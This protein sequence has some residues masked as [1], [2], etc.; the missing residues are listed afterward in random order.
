MTFDDIDKIYFLHL[1]DRYDREK[2]LQSQLDK[3]NFPKDKVN[4]WWTCRRNISNEIW[5]YIPLL[6]RENYISNNKYAN[7]KMG[8]GVF[9][10][11]L[12]HYTIIRTSYERDFNHILVCE[13]D[14]KFNVD[15]K[16]FKK[17]I[18]LIPTNYGIC[19]F[20]NRGY[21]ITET[22]RTLIDDIST[23]SKPIPT[24]SDNIKNPY[25]IINGP[26]QST[27]CYLLDRNGM[28]AIINAYNQQFTIAD[29]I[30]DYVNIPIYICNYNIIQNH[31]Y[32]CPRNEYM[33]SD[34]WQINTDWIFNKFK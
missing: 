16:L 30:F 21:I 12:E 1:S 22:Q 10:C 28:K 8:G 33:F 18:E 20:I 15:L 14:I 19:K 5:K 34:L 11:S 17:F 9:N 6:D 7:P 3:M 13:D 26:Y 25:K 4:I 31:D 24:N 23:V 2:W 32:D 29:Q 27:C